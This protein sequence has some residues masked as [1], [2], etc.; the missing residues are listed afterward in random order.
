MLDPS[1]NCSTR[2][3]EEP[4]CLVA[5]CAA[6]KAV[7]GFRL[8]PAKMHSSPPALLSVA[9]ARRKAELLLEELSLAV[10]W[11]RPLSAVC[12][13]LSLDA[14]LEVPELL[15]DEEALADS[16]RVAATAP[17]SK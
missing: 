2:A 14:V 7:W 6:A 12:G 10:K 8:A 13:C 17:P 4:G 11:S 15:E 16:A 3:V 9:S 5:L 1:L